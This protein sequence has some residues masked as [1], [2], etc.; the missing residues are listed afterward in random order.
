MN[1]EDLERIEAQM[2]QWAPRA[3]SNRIAQ[4]VFSRLPEDD[5]RLRLGWMT[6]LGPAFTVVTALILAST[7]LPGPVQSSRPGGT[8]IAEL[9]ITQLTSDALHRHGGEL[10]VNVWQQVTSAHTNY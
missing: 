6:C 1:N 9:S 4:R 3:P 10:A 8:N 5:A 2:Q 7:L